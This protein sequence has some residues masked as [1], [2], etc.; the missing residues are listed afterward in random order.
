[1]KITIKEINKLKFEERMTFLSWAGLK[2]N[3]YHFNMILN[4]IFVSFY[5][6][7]IFLSNSFFGIFIGLIGLFGFLISTVIDARNYRRLSWEIVDNY[8]NM[9][10]NPKRRKK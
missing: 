6:L 4:A 2:Q 9:S 7:L 8:F 10:I 1:M 5:M 3:Q